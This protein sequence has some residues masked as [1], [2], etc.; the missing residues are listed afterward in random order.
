MYGRRD[1]RHKPRAQCTQLMIRSSI[2]NTITTTIATI[3]I[4][5]IAIT[6]FT[7]FTV[8]AKPRAQCTVLM[9]SSTVIQSTNIH[10]RPTITAFLREC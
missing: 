3:T 4:A 2:M 7:V 8:T 9:I 10:S 5:A 1:S 6:T